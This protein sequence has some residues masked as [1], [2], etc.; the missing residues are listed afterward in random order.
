MAAL[1]PRSELPAVLTALEKAMDDYGH[2]DAVPAEC[3]TGEGVTSATAEK[4]LALL[5]SDDIPLDPTEAFAT[6][7]RLIGE[8]SE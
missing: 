2:P 1:I 7:S 8:F 5:E 6:W 4:C 3:F